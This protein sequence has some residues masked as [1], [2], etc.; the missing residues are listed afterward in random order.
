MSDEE[1]PKS[2]GNM[3][4]PGV[5]GELNEE[6]YHPERGNIP[7]PDIEA[8]EKHVEEIKRQMEENKMK[9]LE[10][11]AKL[12][13]TQNQAPIEQ[14]L[15]NA[16]EEPN[17]KLSKSELKN[18]IREQMASGKI[19]TKGTIVEGMMPNPDETYTGA[20]SYTHLTLP[21]KRIV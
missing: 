11:E 4:P 1:R 10:E 5:L 18:I 8:R 3:V 15:S 6:G 2:F 13:R 14:K 16:E 19:D 17:L 7:D 21:T 20:V 12:A 9:K